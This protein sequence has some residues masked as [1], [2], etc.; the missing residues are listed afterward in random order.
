MDEQIIKEITMKVLDSLSSD[1]G[2]RIPIGISGRHAHLCRE[3]MDILFGK[4]SELTFMK[5]LMGGQFAAQECIAIVSPKLKTIERVRVLGPLRGASQ[6]E[7]SK[8]DSF[9][10]SLPV[11]FR[12]SGDVAGSAPI[13]LVG[14]CGAVRLDEGLIIA[15]RHIHMPPEDARRLGVADRDM[16]SVQAGCAERGGVFK[17]V[18]V[19]VDKSFTLEMHIDA[20]E[21]NCFGVTTGAFGVIV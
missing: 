18:L 3:H 9:T 1:D 2:K 8:T 7:I 12:E 16:V 4:G 5:E 15:K 20:D 17:H 19:R 10:L 14:P 6:V 21:A 13:T 11:P